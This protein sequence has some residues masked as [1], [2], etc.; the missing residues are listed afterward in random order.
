MLGP[1]NREPAEAGLGEKQS[2]YKTPLVLDHTE[3]TNMSSLGFSYAQ[4]AKGLAP[5]SNVSSN[6]VSSASSDHG[7]KDASIA[8]DTSTAQAKTARS[9]P[10][11][12]KETSTI[13]KS[14]QSARSNEEDASPQ[15]KLPAQSHDAIAEDSKV[16]E[17][18]HASQD[19]EA[20]VTK[21]TAPA[22]R[23]AAPTEERASQR[24][25]SPEATDAQEKTKEADDDWEKVSI[26]SSTAEKELKAAPI[27]VV[28]I[29]A[30]RSQ[31]FQ[32]KLKEQA[33]L[34]Q[35]AT[36]TS[37]IRPRPAATASDDSKKKMS[38][39]DNTNPEASNIQ[40]GRV[41]SNG[42]LPREP[43]NNDIS[44]RLGTQTSNLSAVQQQPPVDV[45]SWPTPET[46]IV[47]VGR[48]SSTREQGERGEIADT[49]PANRKK[50]WTAMP[51]VPSVRFET[52]IPGAARRGGRP[53]NSRGG[54][55]GGI[56]AHGE[57]ATE[58]SEPG[59][60]GPPPLPK[61]VSDQDRGRKSNAARSSRASS[62]PHEGP[63]V[64]G[65]DD[66]LPM[67]SIP[68]MKETAVAS[69]IPVP[70]TQSPSTQDPSRSSS[71]QPTHP[72]SGKIQ[73]PEFDVN[74]FQISDATQS[75]T[76]QLQQNERQKGSNGDSRGANDSP[77][78]LQ[79]KE[80]QKERPGNAQKSE[81]WRTRG[82]R[83]ERGRG[84]YRGRGGH[85]GYNNP[86]FT[87]PLPQNGFDVNKQ[88]GQSDIRARQQSQPFGSPFN[89][90]RS[91]PRS[92]SIPVHMLQGSGFYQPGPGF[93]QALPQIQ[94]EMGYSGYGQMPTGM[95][96]GIMSAMPYNEQLNGYALMSMVSTQL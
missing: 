52:Q 8:S 59:S 7:A 28:N 78:K 46:A 50:E 18:G 11:Q 89:S 91:N 34:R 47:D 81:N 9:A 16:A 30:Q 20:S 96:A 12:D 67:S 38:G 3:H 57:R 88:G 45:A 1:T 23:A 58:K 26:P 13:S 48:R 55:R 27:P 39:R 94:T 6:P 17:A 29:W 86:S 32:A 31:S 87:S 42:R 93:P 5:S 2:Y 74:P 41:T 95:P 25:G 36:P 51:F 73:K 64:G 85:A 43:H 69:E 33:T 19:A 79:S 71:R 84:S 53:A 56:A 68:D 76:R 44:P 66:Q 82:E 62:V 15:T 22:V 77:E 60:M 49:K 61:T 75:P 40:S 90:T 24:S 37:Q 10:T 80:W 92:Q 21:D 14:L 4:A 54:G 72:A 83:S 65:T 63:K 70:G 35:T